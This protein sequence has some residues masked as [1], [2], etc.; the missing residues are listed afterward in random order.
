MED[1]GEQGPV[2]PD[3][4]LYL[5]ALCFVADE[6]INLSTIVVIS[7][8]VRQI[9]GGVFVPFAENLLDISRNKVWLTQVKA[10]LS[11]LRSEGRQHLVQVEVLS[12]FIHL[13]N[14]VSDLSWFQPCSM[15][16]NR[17]IGFQVLL[18]FGKLISIYDLRLLIS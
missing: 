8:H 13:F 18:V 7:K 10:C 16:V 4:V 11:L 5:Q 3:E 12:C 6:S 9:V 15:E 14:S 17:Y 2:H 1:V